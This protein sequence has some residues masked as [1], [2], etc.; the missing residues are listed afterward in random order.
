MWRVTGHNDRPTIKAT[1]GVHLA[2]RDRL[3]WGYRPK[4]AEANRSDF[5]AGAMLG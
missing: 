3:P 1:C 4:R 2:L 5:H